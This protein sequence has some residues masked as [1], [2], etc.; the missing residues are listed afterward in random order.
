MHRNKPQFS[1]RDSLGA[2]IEYDRE[3][4]G[5]CYTDTNWF[6][7]SL[8]MSE[9]DLFYLLLASRV[10]EQYRGT[11]VAA[12]V[13]Q[14]FSKVAGLL[15]DKLAIKPELVFTRFSFTSPPSDPINE[16]IWTT[17][18]RGLLRQR[19]VE[20]VY[21]RPDVPEPSARTL[22]P[23]HIAN[24]QGE[25]YVFAW[26]HL[27]QTVLQFA[28]SRIEKAT[29]TGR[30]FTVQPGFDRKKLDS[31]TFGRFTAAVGHKELSVR[32]RFAKACAP[33]VT[34]K[35][36]GPGQKIHRRRNGDIELTFR[37]SGLYGVQRWVLA[38]GH[39]VHVLAPAK[40]KQMVRAEIEMMHRG[41]CG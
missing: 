8:S 13:E 25:W 39:D 28:M 6:L 15:P 36:W 34:E 38:W 21:R 2:P 19:S 3:K 1:R 35:Q 41:A 16:R 31:G 22:D 18:V 37:A 14:I 33:W 26:C 27:R 23:Y 32:L 11:P 17:L 9:G 5:F 7:P 12:R 29:V 4:R 30:T 20:V 10:L 40:L 24:L